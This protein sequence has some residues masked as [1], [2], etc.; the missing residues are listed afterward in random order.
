MGTAVEYERLARDAGLVPVAVQDVS[1]QV[2]RTWPICARRAVLGLLRDPSYRRFLFR[3]GGPNRIFALT[4]FRIWL[5]YEVGAMR[6]VIFT[7]VKPGSE[8][9][10]RTAGTR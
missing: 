10:A 3:E 5:A 8:P 1:R 4:L 9:V 2:K 7:F 6:Y